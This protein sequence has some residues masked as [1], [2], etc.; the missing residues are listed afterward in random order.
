MNPTITTNQKPEIDPQKLER[1]EHKHTTKENHQ[2]KGKKLKEEKK[3]KNSQ[4]TGNKMA[5]SAYL[6]IVTLNVNRLNAPIKRHKVAN[7]IKKNK[8]L[9]HAAHKRLNLE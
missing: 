9:P 6:S 8:T 1:K 2:T 5:I 4:K 7:W 3:Y